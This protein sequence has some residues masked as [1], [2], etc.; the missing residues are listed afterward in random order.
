MK[1]DLRT[2]RD[3]TWLRIEEENRRDL[4]VRRISFIAW[5][6]TFFVLLVFT[7]LVA[8]EFVHT[9]E[10]QRV[11]VASR[12]TV[13]VTIM[14]LVTVIGVVSL[15][16]AIVSTI[17]VFLRLRTASLNEIQLRLASL[18]AILLEQSESN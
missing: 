17:G 12:E 8:V 9:L 5:G 18:E 15:L 2:Q 13:V 3:Q 7:A 16:I 14:P 1:E 10:L 11:G 6:A 4:V